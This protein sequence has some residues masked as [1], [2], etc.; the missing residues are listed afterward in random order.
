MN[1]F[2]AYNRI[3]KYFTILLFSFVAGGTYLLPVEVFGVSLYGL[4]WFSVFYLAYLLIYGGLKFQF[5]S[6]S[7][8]ALIV[9]F[10]TFLYGLVSL[11]WVDSPMIAIKELINIL[12]GLIFIILFLLIYKQTS[13]YKE[14]VN[15][16]YIAL[17]IVFSV[18]FYEISTGNHISGDVTLSLSEL[19]SGHYAQYVPYATFGNPNN[20]AFFLFACSMILVADIIKSNSLISYLFL[21]AS[22]IVIGL[23]YS[24]LTY[25]AVLLV[26]G[27]ILVAKRQRALSWLKTNYFLLFLI[28][29]VLG[30]L[31]RFNSW[32]KHNLPKDDEV[33]IK[34]HLTGNEIRK[35][36]IINGLYLLKKSNYTGVGPGH[37]QYYHQKRIIKNETGEIDG[38]HNGLIELLSQYGVP[39]FIF[40]ILLFGWYILKFLK[41]S[42]THLNAWIA[43]GFILAIIP[44]SA[45]NSIFL[46]NPVTWTYLSFLLVTLNE[47]MPSSEYNEVDE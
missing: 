39:I 37:F 20:L 43:I 46:K 14:I 32:E 42:A 21:F 25:L 12:F 10:S 30:A 26:L 38:A 5:N 3:V 22:L 41:Y 18:C 29:I 13:G 1:S 8:H 6:I 44:L 45:T 11:I 28:P 2:L 4:R 16:I 15:G 9:I 35:N 33:I 36:L 27:F 17:I 24:K 47:L 19:H 7:K 40:W 34:K 23:T 31:I